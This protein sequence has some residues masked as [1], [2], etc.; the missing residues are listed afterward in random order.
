[1]LG[2]S[3]VEVVRQIVSVSD[4]LLALRHTP[5]EGVRDEVYDAAR[6]AIGYQMADYERTIP[7]EARV[8]YGEEDFDHHCDNV[9][10]VASELLACYPPSTV[11]AAFQYILREEVVLVTYTALKR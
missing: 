9:L 10:R 2:L 4:Y 11:E 1:M 3:P 8:L 7:E 6:N 5:D